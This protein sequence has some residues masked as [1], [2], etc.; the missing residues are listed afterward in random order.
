MTPLSDPP[1]SL[2]SELR[3]IHPAAWLSAG[4]LLLFWY[5]LVMPFFMR[6]V[7]DARE[8]TG[9]I[10]FVGFFDAI[11]LL[12]VCYTNV[13][14]GRRG[15]GRTLPTLLVAVVPFLG[16]VAY[17]LVRKPVSRPCPACGARVR[18]EFVFCPGCGQ[19][20]E[21]A[22]PSCHAQ[23]APGW[24]HCPSCGVFLKSGIQAGAPRF[25]PSSP[26]PAAPATPPPAP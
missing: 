13:D 1:V 20:M 15:M 21:P 7:Q 3:L 22:C 24:A 25:P 26:P 14:A 23:V 10:A 18:P 16:F 11:W 4:F 12:L 19:Q 9:I 17:L 8:L 2:R 6:E 5:G